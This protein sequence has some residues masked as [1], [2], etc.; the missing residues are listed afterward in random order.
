MAISEKT[1]QLLAYIS[2]NYIPPA[3]VTSLMKLSYLIDLIATSKTGKQISNFQYR[4][5]KYGP[6]DQTI[7]T[8][9]NVLTKENV[10][11]EDIG[12][13]NYAEEYILYQFNEKKHTNF[14]KLTN[15][16]KLQI[17][18]V[19]ENLHGLGPKALSEISYKTK[20]MRALGA[21]IDNNKGINQPLDLKA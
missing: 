14:D 10:L 4:R 2:K 7:Y 15:K 11:I 1:K 18:S 19:L 12:H 13:T 17:D 20:P 9:L 16:E 21:K 8:Y 3:T 6:F 5:Y